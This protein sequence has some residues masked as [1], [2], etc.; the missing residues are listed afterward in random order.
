M[1]AYRVRVTFD[2]VVGA[3]TPLAANRVTEMVLDKI[4]NNEMDPDVDVSPVA[5]AKD[6]PPGW[7]S[8]TLIYHVGRED[9][10]CGDLF[11]GGDE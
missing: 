2:V 1:N 3:D 7:D 5:D 11:L 6:L 10:E 4:A 9:I 8:K